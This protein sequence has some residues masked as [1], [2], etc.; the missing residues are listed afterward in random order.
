MALWLLKKKLFTCKQYLKLYTR[1]SHNY[2]FKV[3]SHD[4]SWTTESI[5]FKF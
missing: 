3:G 5:A 2:A 4:I 1:F